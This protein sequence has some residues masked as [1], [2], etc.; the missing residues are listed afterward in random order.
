MTRNVPKGVELLNETVVTTLHPQVHQVEDADGVRY[1]YSELL[2]A[3][4]GS[5][6]I[7]PF[8]QEN[9][10]IYYRTLEDYERL[11]HLAT[12]YDRFLVIGGGFIGSELAAALRLQG[13]SVTIVFPEESL[14][15]SLFHA[16]LAAFVDRTYAERGVRVIRNEEVIALSGQ[17][18][19]LQIETKS[20]K[21]L[22]ADVIVAG[23][24]ID[25]NMQLAE[26][27]G[28]PVE[29]GILVNEQLRTSNV[30]I[31]A[32][33]NVANFF[34]PVVGKRR[35]VEHED[36]ALTMGRVAG[37]IMAGSS[38]QYGCSPMFYSDLFGLGYEA[39]GDLDASL[40]VVAD[41]Q[42]KFTTGVVY[43]LKDER[44][45]G[46]LLWNVWGEADAARERARHGQESCAEHFGQTQR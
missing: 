11:R 10:I 7:L 16:D 1:G 29:N 36:N 22:T 9:Q 19:D 6:R 43:Y 41:W 33:R 40:T 23:I 24:G 18:G 2:L 13:N 4:G 39:V 32:A 12:K 37:R 15:A 8:D 31:Y 5:P 35:R 28:L 3:R 14:C 34:D 38:E 27:A 42:E 45:Q 46:V 44:V 20:G 17:L 30:H 21:T 26:N 25:P